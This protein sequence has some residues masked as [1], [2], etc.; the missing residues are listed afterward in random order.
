MNDADDR[1]VIGTK[2]RKGVGVGSV[3]LTEGEQF[4]HVDT[5]F[6]R[7]QLTPLQARK[8]S[9]HFLRIAKRIEARNT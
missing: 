7:A 4:V 5:G 6:E 8:L 9:R 3:T 2:S 1:E